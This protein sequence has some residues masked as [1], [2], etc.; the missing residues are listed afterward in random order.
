MISPKEILAKAKGFSSK[1]EALVR[2]TYA[3]AQEAHE[4]SKRYSGEPYIEHPASIALHLADMGFGATTIAAALL[5][6]VIEDTDKTAEEIKKKFGDEVLF[7]V[8]GVTKLGHHRYHGAIRHVESLR[9]LLV[10]TASDIRVLIIKLADRYHNMETLQ[11]V[12]KNKQKRIAL[13]TVEIFAPLADRLGM[14]LFKRNLE[15]FAFPFIDPDAYTHTN[16]LR[17]LNKKE[18]EQGLEHVRKTLRRELVKKKFSDFHT[19][20]RIKGLWSLHKKLQRKHDDIT[21]I[22]DIAALRIIVPTIND[23]YTAIGIV[24]SLWKPLPGKFK[25]YIALPKPNGYQ[26]I[27]TTVLT[28][29]AGI[30]EIQVRTKKM[31][32]HAQFGIASHVSYKELG[33]NASKRS[34]ELFSLSWVRALIP[35]LLKISAK[36]SR[37]KVTE[38]KPDASLT[39]VWITELAQGQKANTDTDEFVS[40]LREDFF[41]HRVFIFTP[42]GDVVDLPIDSTPIDF[43][44]A[45]HTDIGNHMRGARVNNKLVSFDSILKNGDVVEIMTRKNAHPTHKWLEYARTSVAR[46]HIRTALSETKTSQTIKTKRR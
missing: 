24:H 1:D 37:V 33:K 3:F 27:H 34:S 22:H 18:T 38:K 28:Q 29:D 31:H 14:G 44:Y 46:K 42:H 19:S 25:D 10:A 6:D 32:E 15:D 13:E 12:P 36:E 41:S 20:I 8:E 5:H 4:G 11:Y 30:V 45:I 16:T 43:A 21:L 23:C 9:R 17:Q 26:S 2:D 39:P 35:S 7:L 40:G